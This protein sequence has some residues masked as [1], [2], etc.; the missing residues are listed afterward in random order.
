MQHLIPKDKNRNVKV[1]RH[2][3]NITKDPRKSLLLVQVLSRTELCADAKYVRPL[4][5]RKDQV[6]NW[7]MQLAT[8]YAGELPEQTERM[9]EHFHWLREQHQQGLQST[10]FVYQQIQAFV[11]YYYE[12]LIH[13]KDVPEYLQQ[14]NAVELEPV[15]QFK[16]GDIEFVCCLSHNMGYYG[17]AEVV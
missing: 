17:W 8:T 10:A 14:C 9:Q 3:Q 7:L 1:L 6:D 2:I 15:R 5:P 13:P 4:A 11:G 12:M 16:W